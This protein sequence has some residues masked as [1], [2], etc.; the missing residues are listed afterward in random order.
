MTG[1]MVINHRDATMGWGGLLKL[2]E[3]NLF[4]RFIVAYSD[5]GT[6]LVCV[7]K[8]I[9]SKRILGSQAG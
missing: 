1:Q 3:E 5:E 6:F 7:V 9:Y 8:D 2:A 4:L